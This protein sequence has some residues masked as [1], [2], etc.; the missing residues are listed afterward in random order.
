M[1]WNETMSGMQRHKEPCIINDGEQVGKSWPFSMT[2][3]W[4]LRRKGLVRN[5]LQLK[6]LEETEL[7]KDQVQSP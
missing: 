4:E 2:G 3:G 5:A 1:I 6:N 7:S